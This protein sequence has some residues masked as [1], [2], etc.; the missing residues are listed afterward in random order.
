[1]LA[2]LGYREAE[3]GVVLCDDSTIRK[4][5][6]SYR[7]KDSSTDVLSFPMHEL[8]SPE[9]KLPMPGAGAPPLL[10][11]DVFISIPTA[12]RQ[13][14]DAPG[15]LREE[16]TKLLAHGLLH[17]LGYAHATKEQGDLMER[18]MNRLISAATPNRRQNAG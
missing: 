18:E 4:L 5:N 8:E 17:L 2:E 1:M 6:A 16:V 3:L 7:N 14:P 11:G 12:I 9:V 10:L 13:A 15:G